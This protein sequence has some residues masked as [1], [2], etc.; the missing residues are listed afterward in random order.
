MTESVRPVG[1]VGVGVAAP[2]LRVPVAEVS[3]AWGASG[4]RGTLGVCDADEDTLTIAWRAGRAALDAAGI[5]AEE[6]SGLWWGTTRPPFAEGPSHAVL[7]TALGLRSDAAGALYG[8]SPH[9]GVDALVGAWDALAAGHAGVGLVIASDALLPGLGTAGEMVTGA[10]AAALV[11]RRIT[12]AGAGGNGPAPP[13]RL[14]ARV[15]RA[16][17]VV[18]RYRGDKDAA[19]GDIYD[20]R[21]FREEVYLPLVT[22]VG[23]A[24][25]DSTAWSLTDPDG[26]LAPAAAKRLGGSLV[27]AAVHV[28]L[29]DTGAAGPLLGAV[30]ALGQAG[31]VGIVGYGGGRATALAVEVTRPV[32]GAADVDGAL[33]GG[34]TVSYTDVLKARGQLQPQSDP[35]PMGVPPAGAAFVRGNVEMLH[36]EGARCRACGTTS[37]P[38]SIHPTCTGCGGTDLEVVPLARRGTVQTFVVNQ[39]MPPPF[40]APL[41]IVVLDLDDGARLML[42]GVPADAASLAIGDTMELVLRRYAVERGIPVYGYKAL[43]AASAPGASAGHSARA[44]RG[45][46]GSRNEEVAR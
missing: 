21:L 14:V 35:I 7:A 38:P 34:T 46:E 30:G 45:A 31:R 25:G 40:Q 4:G 12:D 15:S 6:L 1:V 33:A 22:E 13:A 9:G 2:S 10:G 39:T 8:G 32:P 44:A 26:K 5:A 24:V 19:T 29:G 18:D 11:L 43:R 20:G 27:S 42:Q 36:L 16:L 17:P 37:T 23:R 41:P 28:A 3:A